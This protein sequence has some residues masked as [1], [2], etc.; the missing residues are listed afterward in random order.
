LR[1]LLVF[2]SFNLIIIVHE[3]GHFV[4]AKLS[5]I[6][7]HEF[8]IFMGPRLFGFKIGETEYNFRLLPIGGYVR[9]EGEEEESTSDRAYN[10][11]SLLTRAAVLFSG[12]L[13]NLIFAFII[14]TG[15]FSF[16]GYGTTVID[17]VVEG[18]AGDRAGL[19][20]GDR[21]SSYDGRHVFQTMDLGMFLYY[22][23]KG[24][25][26]DIAVER[27]GVKEELILEADVIPAQERYI[28][29]FVPKS[30]EGSESNVVDSVDPQ[31]PAGKAG[32]KPGD[33]IVKLDD[34]D[35]SSRQQINNYVTNKKDNPIKITVLRSGALEELEAT[36]Y[37]SKTEEQY[38]LGIA[39]GV[40]EPNLLTAAVQA[41]TYS[42]S[43]IRNTY[44]SLVWMITR[45][46]TLNQAMGPIGI[47]NAMN[48][49]V[50]QSPTF[51]LVI[52]NL[53]N[54]SAFISI[55]LGISNLLPIP[56][57]DGSKLIL[58]AVEGIRRKPLPIEK[59]AYIMMAGFIVMLL[60]MVV[61]TYNDI[62][63]VFF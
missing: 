33:R 7:V 16:T 23:V 29:G 35:I 37:L 26:T 48:D 8:S 28:F 13:M 45:K 63:R 61:L 12:P 49:V 39:F 14:L 38:D 44:L 46:V 55:A 11:K 5:N 21:V 3:L 47:I 18:S 4:V 17:T 40:A 2:L 9:M 36:P 27:N 58:L 54:I 42:I 62:I 50:Q 6:Q 56:P 60:L 34:T 20:V 57:A 51:S 22:S 10:K 24:E 19:M 15:I 31:A 43:T 53:L 30:S 25:P 52:L 41:V 1:F 32:L 59:E